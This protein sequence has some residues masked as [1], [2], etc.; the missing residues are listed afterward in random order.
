MF[1]I[2]A[3]RLTA[4]YYLIAKKINLDKSWGE[5]VGEHVVGGNTVGQKL[6]IL[7][8]NGPDDKNIGGNETARPF[9]VGP[10]AREVTR[11]SLPRSNADHEPHGYSPREFATIFYIILTALCL[12]IGINIISIW[13]AMKENRWIILCYAVIAT[14]GTTI[15]A[16]WL[17]IDP[18]TLI[19]FF[20]TLLG[21][22]LGYVYQNL[23][24][25]KR[26]ILYRQ[27]SAYY[28]EF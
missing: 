13:G 8:G 14:I 4:M 7:G 2:I 1:A 9:G 22:I 24:R 21:T 19:F 3:I 15:S 6:W 25:I 12:G 17:T 23:I 28:N 18:F 20:T 16:F 5:A 26:E 10:Q 27:S 11:Q